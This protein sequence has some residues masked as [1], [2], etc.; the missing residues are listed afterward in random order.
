MRRWRRGS[1]RGGADHRGLAEMMR[2]GLALGA[3]PDTF[4]GLL[5]GPWGP[6]ADGDGRSVPNRRVD[7]H[8]HR[9]R[10]LTE[11]LA[12]LGHVAEGVYSARTVLARQRR[13]G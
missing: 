2:L 13:W 11:V 1:T 3:Q 10:S 7:W 6:G 9:G 12:D 5:V 8:W 4:M